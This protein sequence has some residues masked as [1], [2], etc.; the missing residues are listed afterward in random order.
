MYQDHYARRETINCTIVIRVCPFMMV[1]VHCTRHGRLEKNLCPKHNSDDTVTEQQQ[2]K[3]WDKNKQE[4][5]KSSLRHSFSSVGKFRQQRRNFCVVRS[6]ST[7]LTRVS[8]SSETAP[9]GGVYQQR[10]VPGS[11]THGRLTVPCS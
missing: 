8:P 10:K 7:V 5:S 9:S 2:G 11:T 6:H 4:K 1:V 3:S